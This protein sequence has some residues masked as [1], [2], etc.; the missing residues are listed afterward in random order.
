MNCPN[1]HQPVV[2]GAKFCG[3]CGKPIVIASPPPSGL[4][5]NPPLHR[6]EPAAAAIPGASAPRLDQTTSSAEPFD[7]ASHAAGL[8]ERIKNILFTPKTEWPVIESEPTSIGALYIGYVAP[9]ALL[10]ALIAFVHM[11]II[12]VSVPFAGTMRMPFTTGLMSLVTTFIG[13]FIGLFLVGIIINVFAPTFGGTRDLR[14]AL[15]TAAYAF[16]PAWVSSI[17][18]LLPA[19]GT[20]LQFI[21]GCYGIYLLYLGLPIVM[22]ARRES[23]AGYTATVVICT[24]VLGFVFGGVMAIIGGTTGALSGAFGHM[25]ASTAE[26]KEE[27]RDRGAATVGNAIGNMLGTDDK[28]KSDIGSALSNLAKSGEESESSSQSASTGTSTSETSS[29][30]GSTQ[31]AVGAAGGLLSALGG[32]LGGKN[33]VDPVDFKTLKN[34]LPASLPGLQRTNATGET[35]QGLGMKSSNATGTYKGGSGENV[36]I[37]IADISAV[38]GLMDM[39]ES[40]PQTTES[41]G[42]AGFEKE[43]TLGG[44]SVHEKF[45]NASHHGELQTIVAKRF[46]VDVTGDNVD[47][48]KLENYLASVDLNKLESMKAANPK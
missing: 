44:R 15:K 18:G 32:A 7:A 16:T 36:E 46:E 13:G 8:V 31:D 38:S 23:A 14:Q 37:K 3:S 45:D 1:C 34:I 21:A 2:S 28:G 43:V 5:S 22:R 39:A 17:F 33:R 20:L 41:D 27:A 6:L 19:L 47:M 12:G 10:A 26:S 35:N 29:S 25:A 42:T 24:I 40:L 9:L 48:A 4:P 30:S 11:S